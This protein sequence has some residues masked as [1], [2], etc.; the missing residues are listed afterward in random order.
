MR[1]AIHLTPAESKRL[2]GLGV[3]Q[4]EDV[5]DRFKNGIIG[6]KTGTTN[7]YA[8]MALLANRPDDWERIKDH[9][10][11]CGM[12]A[13]RGMC[14]ERWHIGEDRVT[15]A[16]SGKRDTRIPQLAFKKG[17]IWEGPLDE[18]VLREMTE[19]DIY[20]TGAN[21][22]DPYGN[23]AIELGGWN[24]GSIGRVLNTIYGKGIKLLIP[25]GLEKLIPTPIP[26][27]LKYTGHLGLDYAHGEW[28]GTMPMHGKVFTEVDAFRVLTGARAVP[29]GAGGV[30]GAEG[31]IHF[32]IVG[33]E[34]QFNK[35]IDI[36]ENKVRGTKLPDI[37]LQRCEDCVW[38]KSH[39]EGLRMTRCAYV[40][41]HNPVAHLYEPLQA[42]A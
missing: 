3:A 10:K 42:K 23:T 13:G 32:Q 24:G 36:W 41:K 15:R 20:V 25:V 4:L 11:A 40:G 39:G 31:A 22:L 30:K 5:Q 1:A 9:V 21:A 27:V 8:V 7:Y 26:D 18:I 12:A 34:E 19:E 16:T 37:S 28:Y 29:V 14:G 2:I 35:V 33:N 17:E 6:V 38:E